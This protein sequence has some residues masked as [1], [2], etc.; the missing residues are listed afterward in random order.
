MPRRVGSGRRQGRSAAA[1]RSQTAA[2]KKETERLTKRLSCPQPFHYVLEPAPQLS[3]KAR[4]DA[5][6]HCCPTA[7]PSL[8]RSA[9]LEKSRPLLAVVETLRQEGQATAPKRRSLASTGSHQLGDMLAEA[10]KAKAEQSEFMMKQEA[11]CSKRA[12]PS[13]KQTTLDLPIDLQCCSCLE[14][15]PRSALVLCNIGVR[16]LITVKRNIKFWLQA[17]LWQRRRQGQ[18]A[19]SR[20]DFA[21][22]QI[23]EALKEVVPHVF[24]RSCLRTY[25]MGTSVHRGTLQKMFCPACTSML[26][27][28][29]EAAENNYLDMTGFSL[30]VIR[31]RT[32]GNLMKPIDTTSLTRVLGPLDVLRL[33]SL[34]YSCAKPARLAPGLRKVLQEQGARRCSFCGHACILAG[35]CN[36]VVCECC[37][38]V[39]NWNKAKPFKKLKA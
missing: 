14:H 22:E 37:G 31:D 33:S 35:G 19:L 1:K 13:K 27:A 6:Q 4:F 26:R 36:A 2:L 15:G 18:P 25:L 24:C 38:L 34:A 30:D 10:V 16:R 5:L 9:A 7:P 20:R 39:F 23:K 3:L 11:L 12:A 32:W 8:L 29:A 21:A 28:S 17:P